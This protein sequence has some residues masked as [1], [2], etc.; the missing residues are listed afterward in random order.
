M[1]DKSFAHRLAAFAGVLGE[2]V[3]V[4]V[5]NQC[6]AESVEVPRDRVDR[7]LDP[8]RKGPLAA[9]IDPGRQEQRSAI[10]RQVR[11]DHATERVSGNAGD[12]LGSIRRPRLRD[13]P[14]DFEPLHV[15]A[16]TLVVDSIAAN[17][18]V[19]KAEK[20][21]HV[22]VRSDEHLRPHLLCGFRAPRIH[23]EDPATP[24]FD[25]LEPPYRMGELHEARP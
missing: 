7:L 22:G 14:Q 2:V 3:D 10:R 13:R 16:N 5:A 9:L 1:R 18:F 15:A 6:P 23:E 12:L 8:K 24:L 19:Q 11:V 4:T 21:V 20:E 17:H 25:R